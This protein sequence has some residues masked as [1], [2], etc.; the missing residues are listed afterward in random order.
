MNIDSTVIYFILYISISRGPYVSPVSQR[1]P[2]PKKGK[3]LRSS[4]EISLYYHI[5]RCKNVQ[6]AN[7]MCSGT[8]HCHLTRSANFTTGLKATLQ[9]QWPVYRQW[10]CAKCVR[11]IHDNSSM[12]RFQ[13]TTSHLNVTVG[14]F[15]ILHPSPWTGCNYYW[16]TLTL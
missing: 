12:V 16:F 1:G 13:S 4:N 10:W 5:P 6:L 8:A 11:N 7:Q 15:W 3:E 14:S 2:L 9:S